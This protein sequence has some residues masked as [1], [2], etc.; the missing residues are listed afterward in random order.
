M[1]KTTENYKYKLNMLKARFTYYAYRHGYKEEFV[2]IFTKLIDLAKN[3]EREKLQRMKDFFEALLAFHKKYERKPLD[4]KSL[5]S[6]LK[7]E[8][9]PQYIMDDDTGNRLVEYAD[10]LAQYIGNKINPNQL[11]KIFEELRKI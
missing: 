6:K 7:D 2:K 4:D 10:I 9:I 5:E 3:A 8:K 1:S 11:R